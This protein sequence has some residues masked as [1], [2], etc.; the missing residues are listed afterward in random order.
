[1]KSSGSIRRALSALSISQRKKVKDNDDIRGLILIN[2]VASRLSFVVRAEPLG[3]SLSDQIVPAL[4]E[5]FFNFP[6]TS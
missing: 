3:L 6:H 1:M 4:A 2:I 5:V